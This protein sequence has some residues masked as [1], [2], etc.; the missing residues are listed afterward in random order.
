MV[1]EIGGFRDQPIAIL[2]AGS[3]HG[4]NRLLAEL[5]GTV[6]DPPIQELARIGDLGA[7]LSSLPNALF[8]V[9][10]AEIGHGFSALRH[11][12]S[13]PF[14]LCSS[15]LPCFAFLKSRCSLG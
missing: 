14:Q 7:R 9:V 5:S 10:Q 8:Q 6:L 12:V 11:R 1:N 15:V 4:L 2:L 13:R 3:D